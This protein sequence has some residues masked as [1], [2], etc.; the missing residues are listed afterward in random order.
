[1]TITATFSNGHTDTYKGK[2]DVKA[3]WMLVAPDGSVYSGHSLN[4]AASDKTASSKVSE[5]N[6][7]GETRY[8]QRSSAV[9]FHYFAKDAKKAGFDKVE[10]WF[11]ANKK[12]AADFRAAC[13]IEVINL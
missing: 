2:R 7:V 8:P 11:E 13:I 6:R 4:A 3:A 9:T 10:D 5:I 1:M 12:A